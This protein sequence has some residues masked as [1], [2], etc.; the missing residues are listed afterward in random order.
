M[1]GTN[2]IVAS[3]IS[4][5]SYEIVLFRTLIGAVLLFIVFRL[6]GGKAGFLQERRQLIYLMIS[7]GAMGASWMFLYEAYQEIGVGMA[8]L[9]YILRTGFGHG[10]VSAFV[11]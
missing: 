6:T 11:S 8:S 4:L 3:G 9:I 1:F 5:T 2:G 10:A 7:G